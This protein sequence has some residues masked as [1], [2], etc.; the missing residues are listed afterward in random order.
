VTA[1]EPT[2]GT[3]RQVVAWHGLTAE[4]VNPVFYKNN[5]DSYNYLSAILFRHRSA[6]FLCVKFWDQRP[7]STQKILRH[8]YQMNECCVL[9][10][11]HVHTMMISQNP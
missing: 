7:T 5:R 4:E 10:L 6:N 1:L 9:L 11:H 8:Q 3:G 2:E